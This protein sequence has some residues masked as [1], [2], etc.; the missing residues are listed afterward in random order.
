MVDA[1]VIIGVAYWWVRIHTAHQKSHIT[2]A[3]YRPN[4]RLN[5]CSTLMSDYKKKFVLD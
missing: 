3:L 1:V 4:F 5:R 2:E